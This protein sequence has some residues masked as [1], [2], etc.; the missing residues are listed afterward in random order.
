ML[1]TNSKLKPINAKNKM[2]QSCKVTVKPSIQPSASCEHRIYDHLSSALFC[3]FYFT[4]FYFC[5]TWDYTQGLEDASELLY[6]LSYIPRPVF[7]FF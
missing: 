1:F 6:Y 3:L 2:T 4:Y 7:L 5:T